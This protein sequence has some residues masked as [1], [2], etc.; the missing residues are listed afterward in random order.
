MRPPSL[1]QLGEGR[2]ASASVGWWGPK[3]LGGD[4]EGTACLVT[5]TAHP[6]R[7][8]SPPLPSTPPG[9]T[10]YLPTLSPHCRWPSQP[11]RANGLFEWHGWV[12]SPGQEARQAHGRV[13]SLRDTQPQTTQPSWES[14]RSRQTLAQGKGEGAALAVTASQAPGTPLNGPTSIFLDI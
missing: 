9:P 2:G 3:N 11:A 12:T 8:E 1:P 4:S 14:S 10:G 7:A 13:L 5:P 6:G